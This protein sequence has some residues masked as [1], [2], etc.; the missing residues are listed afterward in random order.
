MFQCHVCP[1]GQI[2]TNIHEQTL[3][4]QKKY[5]DNVITSSHQDIEQ[6]HSIVPIIEELELPK[7][8]VIKFKR[9]RRIEWIRV[10]NT[11]SYFGSVEDGYKSKQQ[12]TWL[13]QKLWQCAFEYL[14]MTQEK[15]QMH[16]NR[17]CPLWIQ[18]RVFSKDTNLLLPGTDRPSHGNTCSNR[19]NHTNTTEKV[20]QK[21]FPW[22]VIYRTCIVLAIKLLVS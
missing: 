9:W 6:C 12:Q 11:S 19:R 3:P 4:T 14:Q 8:N 7:S 13:R 22:H 16:R 1:L 21:A 5:N 17:D 2:C 20:Q 10:F 18:F 15:N